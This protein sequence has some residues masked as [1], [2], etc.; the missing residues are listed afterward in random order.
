M[1]RF[2]HLLLAFGGL[3]GFEEC[4]ADKLSG[5]EANTDPATLFSRYINI[6]PKQTSRTI[7]TEEALFIALSAM[8]PHLPHRS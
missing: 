8:D 5:Y 4:V 1:P 2:K 7:R 6:C 3:G